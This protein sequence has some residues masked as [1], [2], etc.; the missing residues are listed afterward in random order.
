M[1]CGFEH[2]D[3][4]YVLG[5]LSPVERRAFEEHLGTCADCARA[6]REVAGLPGLLAR[7]DPGVLEHPPGSEPVPDT[8]LPRLVLEVRRA[9]RRRAVLTAGIAAA[10]LLVAGVVPV[11]LVGDRPDPS[12]QAAPPAASRTSNAPGQAMVPLDGAP[13]QATLALEQ[14]PWGTRLDLACTYAPR[15]DQ[16]HLPKVTTYVLVVRTRDGRTEQ[17]GTWRSLKGRT[18]RLMAA[19]SARRADIA[20][21]EVRTTDGKRVLT[22]TA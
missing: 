1:S 21:V 9:R 13:L 8:L 15:P 20:S 6:V 5:A 11:L 22:L 3:G 12:L 2:H 19:T 16:Y 4:A 17:V 10:A 14:V 7:V 18:M